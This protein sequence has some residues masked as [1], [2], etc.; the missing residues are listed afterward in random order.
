MVIEDGE[1]EAERW[2]GEHWM[3]TKRCYGHRWGRMV[4]YALEYPSTANLCHQPDLRRIASYGR[5]VPQCVCIFPFLFVPLS[6][7]S[8]SLHLIFNA[9]SNSH[10][11]WTKTLQRT[12]CVWKC[13]FSSWTSPYSVIQSGHSKGMFEYN[14]SFTLVLVLFLLLPKTPALRPNLLLRVLL[15]K[16][17]PLQTCG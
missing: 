1:N 16:R 14:L 10:D 5:R 12:S 17:V 2:R 3:I 11:P 8:S 15:F 9:V 13:C 7:F 6:S 4:L